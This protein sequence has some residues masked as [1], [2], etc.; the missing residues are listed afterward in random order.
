MPRVTLFPNEY[1]ELLHVVPDAGQYARQ[2]AWGWA[3]DLPDGIC[4]EVASSVERAVA[5]AEKDW[6]AQSRE[7]WLTRPQLTEDEYA[8]REAEHGA[9]ERRH[10]V[11][12]R[13]LAAL[14]DA[15]S[16]A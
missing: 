1:D 8:R 13:V 3:L 6:L 10:R 5:Q 4:G 12:S 2:D 15:T 7:I 11:L 9:S 14:L 16:G